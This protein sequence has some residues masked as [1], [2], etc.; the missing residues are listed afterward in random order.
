MSELGRLMGVGVDL[1][2][3]DDGV[4]FDLL[5]RETRR[6]GDVLM[7]VASSSIADP[8]VLACGGMVTMNVSTEGYPGRRYHA[9]CGVVDEI[10]NLAIERAKRAFGARYANVQPHSGTT[11]NQ[12][13]MFSLLRP[14]DT[15]LALELKAGGHLSHGSKAAASGNIYN[16]V[17]YGLDEAGFLDYDQA[18]ALAER[19]QP[20]LIICGGSAYPRTLDFARF[21]AIADRVGA[22]LLADISHISGLVVA[23]EHPSPIDEAHFTTTSTYKQLFGPRGGLILMGRDFSAPAPR[24]RKGTLAQAMQRAVFPYFQGT[25]NLSGIA[26][27]A[28]ALDV[29]SRPGFGSLARRIKSNAKTLAEG[30]NAAGYRVVTGG[31]DNHMVLFD[32]LSSG[33]SGYVAEKALETCGI[34]VNKN[35]IP[36]DKKSPMVTSGVRLGTNA[37]AAR[38]MGEAEMRECVRLMVRVLRGVEATGDKEYVLSERVSD[39]VLAGVKVLCDGFPMPRYGA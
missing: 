10:E 21:R 11:A 9:G 13:V 6:Q 30:L 39:E 2:A 22:Y 38:G 18:E 8:S 27:K 1:L 23:G 5:V 32:V 17:Y 4:L 31:T 14:G 26:A 3:R 37:L 34:V 33:V 25:P 20:K 28:R 35:S 15:I 16:A 19:H 29:V 7:M 24:G 12:I 36:G